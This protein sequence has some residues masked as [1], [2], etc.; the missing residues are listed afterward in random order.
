MARPLDPNVDRAIATAALELLNERGFARMSMD[1]L[2]N[3]AGV[4][5]PA[6]YRRFHDKAELVATVIAAQLPAL[7]PPD[8]GDTHAE[9]W[10]AVEQGFPV[11]G[12][13]YVALIGG[14]IAEHQRH[15][16]LIDAFRR[17]VLHPRRAVGRALIERGQERGDVRS[18]ID[19]EAALDLFAGPFLARV[20]AGL[21]TGPRWRKKAFAVWWDIVKERSDR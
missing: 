18:D 21:D 19:P 8:V 17:S 5:K 15:P 16:E 20:F 3:A 7:D 1:A 4:G 10:Q 14:L 9:L 12:V 13:A 2:A 6:I 11:D